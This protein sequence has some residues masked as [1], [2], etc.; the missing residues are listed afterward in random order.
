MADYL[1]LETA[2]AAT[3]SGVVEELAA[4]VIVSDDQVDVT[5]LQAQGVALVAYVPATMAA[6]L[7]AFRRQAGKPG[8]EGD[9][10]ALLLAAGALGGGGGGAVLSVFGRV[11]AVIA[12]ANDYTSTLIQN[13]SSVAGA[14]VTA[15]LDALA[16]AVGAAAA[17]ASTAQSTATAAQGDATTALGDAA[18]AQGDAT[19]ALA[20]AGAA[21]PATRTLTAGAGLSGGGDLSADRTFD[22]S[23]GTSA[24]TATEGNDGRLP[25]NDEKAALAGTSGAPAAANRYV[26]NADGRLSDSRA[27][28]GAASGDLGGSYP[29][30]TVD[31]A[32]G[33]RETAGPQILTLG[34]WLDGEYLRRVG[35]TAVGGTPSGGGGSSIEVVE[36]FTAADYYRS[37]ANQLP[38]STSF[39][40]IWYGWLAGFG[41]TQ[42]LC[43][44]RNA[45]GH[46]WAVVITAK[47]SL[48]SMTVHD[49]TGQGGITISFSEAHFVLAR[50]V[51]LALTYGSG[52]L[53]LYLD[54]LEANASPGSLDGAFTAASGGRFQI[55]VDPAWGEPQEV[56]GAAGVGYIGSVLTQAQIYEHLQACRDAGHRFAAGAPSW[57]HRYDA[58]APGG[59]FPSQWDDLA[60]SAHLER[61]GTAITATRVRAL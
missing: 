58:Q 13:V 8:P 59:S 14:T 1:V 15:A 21:A 29:S 61:V 39:S 18:A 34:S 37:A 54:G 5:Q 47:N 4:G 9:L 31:A 23:F 25:T 41:A 22:V 32:R 24:G 11:G 20:L 45:S 36:G 35:T 50:P 3:R 33:L 7:E 40:V 43:G 52:D 27:P 46:G 48:V 2:R 56:G 30:P 55:G 57:A 12:A 49:G 53:R 51:H 10:T 26:T 28:S 44:N 42:F 16:T 17:A 19:A 60:G 6:P 38:G